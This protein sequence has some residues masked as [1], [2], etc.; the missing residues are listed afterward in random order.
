MQVSKDAQTGL[1]L[2]E[3]QSTKV[4]AELLNAGA[5]GN[6]IVIGAQIGDLLFH[7][8]FLQSGVPVRTTCA[9]GDV[10]IDNPALLRQKLLDVEFGPDPDLPVHWFKATFTMKKVEREANGLQQRFLPALPK[11]LAAAWVL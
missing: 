7:E 8:R 10:D 6:K 1:L 5:N 4:A 9:L 11:E 3:Q 2:S